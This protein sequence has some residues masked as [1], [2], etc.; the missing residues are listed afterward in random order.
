MGNWYTSGV[1]NN[2]TWE[3]QELNQMQK[4]SKRVNMKM[5]K[6]GWDEINIIIIIIIIIT[7]VFI[8]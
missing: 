3:Q 1:L 7:I 2:C 4:A 5:H 8:V 6:K